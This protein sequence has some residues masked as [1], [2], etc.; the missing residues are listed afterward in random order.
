MHCPFSAKEPTNTLTTDHKS[1]IFCLL[2]RGRELSTCEAQFA[3][4]S[5]AQGDCAT[6]FD[7]RCCRHPSPS[8]HY[9]GRRQAMVRDAGVSCAPG[10]SAFDR[11][12]CGLGVAVRRRMRRLN[13]KVILGYPP[14][15]LGRSEFAN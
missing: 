3:Q 2:R 14:K 4:L 6:L 11:E 7:A 5:E 10:T 9:E 12:L 1:L 15:T 13:W 8:R